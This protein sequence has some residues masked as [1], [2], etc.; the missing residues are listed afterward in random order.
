MIYQKK[1]ELELSYVDGILSF[2]GRVSALN[3]SAAALR[4]IQSTAIIMVIASGP[5]GLLLGAANGPWKWVIC[6]AF[7]IFAAA[8]AWRMR[9]ISQASM[10]P[11]RREVSL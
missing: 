9:V 10:R 4:H 6:A 5:L 8:G 1:S 7:L 2:P 11:Y 3:V